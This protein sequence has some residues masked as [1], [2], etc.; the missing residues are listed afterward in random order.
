[1]ISWIQRTFQQHFKWLFLILLAV[2]IISFVFITNASSGFGHTAKQAPAKPFFGINL[3]SSEDT[4]ALVK[5]ATL[6]VQLHGMQIRSEGQFQQYALQRYAALHLAG[7][8]NLPT[9]TNEDLARHI[10]TLRAFTDASGRFDAKRY[11]D[12]RDSLKTN[13]QLHESDVTRVLMDDVTY[14]QVLKLLSGPGYVLPADVQN[15]LNLADS[16]WSLEAVTI[17]QASFKPSVA[18]TDEALSKYFE[19]NAPRY[20]VGPKV[21]VSYIDF[22]AS[23]YVSQVTVTDEA[24]RA[25]YN[26][27][28]S[29][30]TKSADDKPAAPSDAGFAAARKQVEEAYKLDRAQALA[31]NAAG[32]FA[33]ALYDN[34]VTPATLDAFLA[35]RKLT[36][37]KV[38][39]FNA[40]SPAAE[41]GSDR[42]LVT[43]ALKTGPERLFSDPVSTGRGSAILVWN[44]T[45]PSRQPALNDV[46]A[47]VTAD[48]TESEKRRLFAEA[49]RT[50]RSALETRLKAGDTLAKAVAAS[51]NVIPAKLGTKSWPAFT[52][53]NPPQDLDYNV[54]TAIDGLQKGQL[55]QMVSGTDQGLIIY[56]ADKK[57]PV[58]EASSDKFKDTQT[59]LAAITASR[60]GG[61]ALAALV[62]AE[63]AKTAPATP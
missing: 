15:Q 12:F 10:Q 31:A 21:G 18:V 57:L 53:S 42:A 63:L 16:V 4:Q 11:A 30:F 54:Y 22:P 43:E 41:L 58:A 9:P 20:E 48:F 14:Q 3:G 46:K 40:E 37:K 6:S 47:R 24:L 2:V 60:N 17:D 51:A 61:A 36:S 59:R 32:D 7:Q 1:M 27:N 39:P 38:A 33:V 49:G 55:S 35:P 26:A 45:V 28:S 52:L 62:D 34:K 56:A 19:Y 44:E 25:Y 50:L 5:D 23:A 8:L 13:P 29:R